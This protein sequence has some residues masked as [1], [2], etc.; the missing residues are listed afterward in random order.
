[1]AIVECM[2]IYEESILT[3]LGLDYKGLNWGELG[4]QDYNGTPAKKIYIGLGVI[5]TSID[6]N[7]QH[8]ALILDLSQPITR[9]FNFDVL[10]NYGT[11]EHV[12]EQYECFRNIHNMVKEGGVMIHGVPKN[13]SWPGHG[14]YY[15]EEI[16]FSDLA[17]LC[18]Y[19]I[20]EIKTWD[21]GFYLFPRNLIGTVFVKAEDNKFIDKE[22]FDSIKGILDSGNKTN[23]QNY[24]M[25]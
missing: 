11:T 13:G 8:G 10:T 19:N 25:R 7:G 3:R 14:R 9:K 24:T 5:H 18:N 6:L 17:A 1:M 21:S 20:I 4:N 15:F 2:K 22:C 16:F 23:T 12:A